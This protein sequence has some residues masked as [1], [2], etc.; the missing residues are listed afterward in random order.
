MS[1]HP[2]RPPISYEFSPGRRSILAEI[3]FPKKVTYQGPIFKALR[4]GLREGVVRAQLIEYAKAFLE[5]ELSVYPQWFDPD[6]YASSAREPTIPTLE[7]AEKR[8]SMYTSP[9]YGWSMY[10]VDGVFKSK[11]KK[12]G[13][14]Q[15][16][17]ERVQIIR[18]IFAFSHPAEKRARRAGHFDVYRAILYWVMAVYGH[19]EDDHFWSKTEMNR[20]LDRHKEW[21]PAQQRYARRIYPVIAGAIAKWIDDCGLFVFGYLVRELWTNVVRLVGAGYEKKLEDEIWVSSVFHF[22]VNIMKPRKESF[23]HAIVDQVPAE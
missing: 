11:R 19:T 10:E 14:Y 4:D 23:R 8:M 13:E 1:E 5:K 9:F 16:D 7:Q 3:Y 21:N 20:F 17:E 15:V 12:G 18:L 6:R 2:T 22:N